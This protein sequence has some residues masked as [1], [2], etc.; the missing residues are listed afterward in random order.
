MATDRVGPVR[1]KRHKGN[2]IFEIL[3]WRILFAMMPNGLQGTMLSKGRGEQV[4][5]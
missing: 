5:V 1:T 2:D 3:L 4:I